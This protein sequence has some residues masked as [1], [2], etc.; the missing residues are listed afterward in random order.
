MSIN[1]STEDMLHITE[2]LREDLIC[3]QHVLNEEPDNLEAARSMGAT[4]QIMLKLAAFAILKGHN[5]KDD[6]YYIQ[7]RS[8]L[9]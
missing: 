4:Q 9:N 3:N 6:P 8:R 1:L 5:L 7:T 2:L